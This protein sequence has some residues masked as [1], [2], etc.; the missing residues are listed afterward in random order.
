MSFEEAVNQVAA[1]ETQE[2]ALKIAYDILTSRHHGSRFATLTHFF[3]IFETNV[4]R[5]WEAKGPLLCTNFN[6]LL[7][8]ILTESGK[9][10][11]D[12][13]RSRWT[14]I[15]LISPHQYLQ[16]RVEGER[17]IDIDMWGKMYGVPFGSHAH[18]F[19]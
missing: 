17:W 13:F 12:A 15:W 18:G 4:D 9:F 11:D 16:I 10:T 5:L 8:A 2:Q 1:A 3:Q 14:M 7:K 6:Y 19:K